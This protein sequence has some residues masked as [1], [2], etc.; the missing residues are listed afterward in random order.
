[1]AGVRPRVLEPAMRVRQVTVGTDHRGRPHT[2]HYFHVE[3]V[4]AS[5]RTEPTLRDHWVTRAEAK[6]ADVE[7]RVCDCKR[8]G[9]PPCTKEPSRGK[10][11]GI[12]VAH[13]R[14]LIPV[15]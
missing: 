2:M 1:M 6:H 11:H 5:M 9:E 7:R 8:P 15:S 14:F 10:A 12:E 4:L 3:E 13:R